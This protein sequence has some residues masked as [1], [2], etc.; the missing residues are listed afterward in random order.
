MFQVDRNEVSQLDRSC[1]WLSKWH[2]LGH[3]RCAWQVRG[4]AWCSA[5]CDHDIIDWWPVGWVQSICERNDT[6]QRLVMD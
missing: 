6:Q 2:T 5:H 1:K 4:F 3:I